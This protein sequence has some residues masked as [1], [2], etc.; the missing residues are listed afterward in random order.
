MCVCVYACVRVCHPCCVPVKI[1]CE[2]WVIILYNN[3]ND[4]KVSM[5]VL[6]PGILCCPQKKKR[7]LVIQLFNIINIIIIH[8]YLY[9][10]PFKCC[11][12]PSNTMEGKG[13]L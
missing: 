2:G 7:K 8:T 4:I 13:L 9:S 11:C 12:S 10:E 1:Q 3:I 6:S 5:Y